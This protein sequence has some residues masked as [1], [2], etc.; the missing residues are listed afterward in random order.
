MHRAADQRIHDDPS[1]KTQSTR[2]TILENTMRV[3]VW[4][5][6]PGVV[7]EISVAVC[8]ER[9]T[10]TI[11]LPLQFKVADP[12]ISRNSIIGVAVQ[13]PAFDGS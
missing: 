7:L 9:Q 1:I 8:V 4:W 3:D 11:A 10:N 2:L 13:V 6:A 12:L 5:Y